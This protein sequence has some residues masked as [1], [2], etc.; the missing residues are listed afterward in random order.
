SDLC[1]GARRLPMSFEHET[2]RGGANLAPA[3]YGDSGGHEGF[4]NAF[5]WRVL[6]GILLTFAG[7]ISLHLYLTHRKVE[8]LRAEVLSL[9][10][11][12]ILPVREELVA[13][14]EQI[15][16]QVLSRYRRATFDSPYVAPGFDLDAMREQPVLTLRLGRRRDLADDEVELVVEHGAPDEI[17]RCLG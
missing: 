14:R 3:R 17:G 5:P 6:L 12:E 16:R 4:R 7:I 9:V 2:R 11:T 10:E 15:S 8:A 13:L 1:H